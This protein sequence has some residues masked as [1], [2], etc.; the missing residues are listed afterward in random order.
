MFYVSPIGGVAIRVV[1]I[2]VKR[3]GGV[4]RKGRGT[5]IRVKLVDEAN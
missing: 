4:D 5:F 3:W 1:R 2:M